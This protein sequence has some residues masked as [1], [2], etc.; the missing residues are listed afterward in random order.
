DRSPCVCTGN[1]CRSPMAEGLLK[2]MLKE[3]LGEASKGFHVPPLKDSTGLCISLKASSPSLGSPLPLL[4]R[5][6][7]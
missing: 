3:R 4:D 6:W 2:K 7:P 5:P 1:I